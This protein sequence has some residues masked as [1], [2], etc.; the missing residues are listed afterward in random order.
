MKNCIRCK[1]EK[2]RA[3]FSPDKRAS[4]GLQSI[5]RNCSKVEKKA[6][7][8]S[9]PDRA[10]AADKA[11]RE[12]NP[13]KVREIARRKREKGAEKI[14]A[15]KKEYYERVK[16]TPSYQEKSLAYRLSTKQHKREYDAQYRAKNPGAA[17]Q[18]AR[19]W[20]KANP[21]K[22]KLIVHSYDARRRKQKQGGCTTAALVAWVNAQKKVCY[23]CGVKCGESFHIDHY[24]PLSKGGE[25]ALE[26]LV[27]SCAPCNLR[28]N[29]KDPYQFAAQVGRLF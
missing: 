20:R 26:N 11:W 18:R 5:C 9:D 10:R 13:E 6:R 17:I 8:N 25:H 14:K 23:W 3:E 15:A 1:V 16:N 21:E 28:K 12:A 22:R 24:V 29:A 27:I 19:E 4:D 2:E 7:R